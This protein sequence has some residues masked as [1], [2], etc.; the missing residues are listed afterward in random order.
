MWSRD[1]KYQNALRLGDMFLGKPHHLSKGIGI[2]HGN[3]G[4]DLAVQPHI[5]AL[6]AS[7]K[8]AIRKPM[9]A[10]CGID[11]YNPQSSKISLAGPTIT[12]GKFPTPFDRF[13][14]SLVRFSPGAAIPFGMLQ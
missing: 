9:Q 13:T 11:P 2:M 3:I 5:G 10:S 6:E 12:I 1:R 4:Q 7:H 14:C 8:L